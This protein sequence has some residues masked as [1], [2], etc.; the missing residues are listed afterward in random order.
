VFP[1]NQYE[2]QVVAALRTRFEDLT[3]TRR[4]PHD[5]LFGFVRS[6]QPRSFKGGAIPTNPASELRKWTDSATKQMRDALALFKSLEI[7]RFVVEEQPTMDSCMSTLAYDDAST[8]RIFRPFENSE[9]DVDGGP[10]GKGIPAA[11]SPP[12]VSASAE[13]P[14]LPLAT[15]V[16][17][18]SSELLSA[19][20]AA[21]PYRVLGHDESG[22]IAVYDGLG[23]VSFEGLL[24]SLGADGALR[25]S[26]A[27]VEQLRLLKLSLF[28]DMGVEAYYHTTIVDLRGLSFAHLKNRS[29]VRRLFAFA[30]TCYPE[31]VHRIYLIHSPSAFPVIWKAIRPWL[32][33]D[34]SEKIHVLSHREAR[35]LLQQW[36]EELDGELNSM[37]ASAS[38]ISSNSS[39]VAPR[40]DFPSS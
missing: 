29:F 9:D 27:R 32:D 14:S 20:D 37:R 13:N 18:N 21:W 16:S 3:T 38:T 30:S 33:P 6:N 40:K 5:M 26:A 23:G 36:G 2:A 1:A 28:E 4:L 12:S 19:F 31:T 39:S 35:D 34:T 15:T 11:A 25:A 24:S 10:S 7:D 17:H 8:S 22:H